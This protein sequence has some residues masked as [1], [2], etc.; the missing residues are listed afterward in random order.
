MIKET[1]HVFIMARG[2][3]TRLKPLTDGICKSCVSFGGRHKIIDFVLSN[4]AAAGIEKI[5]VLGPS[6]DPHLMSHLQTHW[7]NVILEPSCRHEPLVGNAA[8]IRKAL[9]SNMDNNATHIGIFPSDQVILFDQRT[10]LMQHIKTRAK[11]SILTQWR[12][13]ETVS[14]FGVVRTR[15]SSIIDF[16]EKPLD[17]PKNY[18]E[19]NQCKINMGIYWFE[20]SYL[21]RTLLNDKDNPK[22]FN[23]F[24]H[25]I[26][27]MLI[28]E[29][30]TKC[31]NIDSTHP[32]EDV[33]TIERY[34]DAHWKYLG[35]IENWNIKVTSPMSDVDYR[36][37]NSPIPDSTTIE[38]CIIFDSVTIGECCHLSNVIIDSNCT[39]EDHLTISLGTTIIGNVYRTPKCIIIPKNSMVQYDSKQKVITVVS[40]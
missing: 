6:D 30:T 5:T 25:N 28:K 33:G 1:I 18:I 7:P 27:P 39:L 24:G 36:Y 13:A 17:I 20:R 23:D 12:D 32:W 37:S 34:W 19:N 26:I 3:G 4:L 11:S 21:Y 15:G 14:N 29:A 22:S 9:E 40:R 35:D 10:V 31:I 8:S 38:Q 2:Q 16:I